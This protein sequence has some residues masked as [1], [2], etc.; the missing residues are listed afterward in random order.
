MK[1]KN[2]AATALAAAMAGTLLTS[3]SQPNLE[4][5]MPFSEYEENKYS[6]VVEGSALT[7]YVDI[8]AK[9][10]GDGSESAPFT[11]IQ[12]AQAKIREIKSGDG[13]PAG[14]ITVL[15]KDGEY[16]LDSAIVFTEEDSGT[17]ECPITYVSETLNGAVLSGGLILSSKDF[18][19]ITA[20]EKARIID[21]TAKDKIVRVDLTKYG[22]TETDWGK[23]YAYGSY[24]S[25]S[26]YDGGTGPNMSELFC[27]GDRMTLARYP[28][29]GFVY[30]GE[31]L[32]CGEA[33]EYYSDDSMD[34]RG[35]MTYN[36]DYDS[37]RNPR[38]GT[39]KLSD[40]IIERSTN[41]QTLDDVW[42]FGYMKWS[43]ADASNPVKT[44]DVENK[45][46]T[47][48]QAS[49]YGISKGAHFYFFNVFEELDSEGEY[50]IDRVNGILYLYQ[51]EDFD[52]A[53]IMMSCITDNVVSASNVSY[54]TLKGFGVCGTRNS[55]ISM[56]GNNYVVD[57]CKVYNVRSAGIAASGTYVTV[58]NCEITKVGGTGIHI[59]GGDPETLTPSNN[60]VY[61]NYI[62][63]WA[64]VDRTYHSGVEI[65]GCG[66]LVSHNEL[67][68][69]PHQA[70]GWRGPNHIVE[71][72][73][74]YDVCFETSDC[75]AI[76]GGRNM[77]SYGC[78]F[79]YNYIHDV[80]SGEAHAHGIY[81]D[82]GLS[83][84]TAYGN[85]IVNATSYGFLIGGGR[86][87][88]VENNIVINLGDVPIVPPIFYD[89]RTRDETIYG[90]AWF[91]HDEEL[92]NGIKLENDIWTEA[93]PTYGDLIR[94]YNG[95]DGDVDDPMLSSNPANSSVKNNISYIMVRYGGTIDTDDCGHSYGADIGKFSVIENNPIFLYYIADFPGWHNENFTMKVDSKAK[96]LCPDFE[97]IP[98]NEI[99]RVN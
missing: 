74:I 5:L 6:S 90:S 11:S 35:E 34:S 85:I 30:T 10:G 66:N 69:S 62:H 19:P 22:L 89:Q 83:G 59:N 70:I 43:W 38:G 51:P 56:S 78:I 37:L 44:I 29:E 88:V 55:G 20:E 15:V 87:N 16:K 63:D 42:T 79:R 72:N 75:G 93:F 32:D 96:E 98:F 24:N 12:E 23:M 25:G 84:Q 2:I 95:Y 45:T 64:V 36:P 7:L 41:W 52:S 33:R 80:G 28:N 31:V 67:A 82:D 39:A 53:E 73:E 26:K 99:G 14:G 49:S 77:T 17:E 21:S 54:L 18:E 1:L 91:D 47:F 68:T 27:D 97:P 92:A 65:D 48:A 3:C 13:L 46:I 50:Y 94:Y 8:N 86:D 71:Y 81:W 9:D 57:S 40:E 61:N 4:N 58:Q 60:L 76:Y